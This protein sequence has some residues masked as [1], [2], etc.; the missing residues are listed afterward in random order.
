MVAVQNN[1]PASQIAVSMA[2]VLLCQ[3]FGGTLWLSFAETVLDAGLE[4]ELSTYAPGISAKEVTSAGI[5]G[6]RTVIPQASVEGVIVAYN[7]AINHVFYMVAGTAAA[8]FICS[9][10]LGWKSIKKSRVEAHE[11]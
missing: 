3:N 5:S 8:A 6:I 10:G 4:T 1:L 11:A 9:W 7:I 2:F